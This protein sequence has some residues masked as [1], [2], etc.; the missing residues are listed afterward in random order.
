MGDGDALGL[1]REPSDAVRAVAQV[2]MLAPRTSGTAPASGRSPCDA[3]AS[4]RPIVAAEDATR[5]ANAA[6]AATPRIGVSA[7]ARSACARTALSLSGSMPSIMSFSP[8]KMRPNPRT[9][10]AQVL[11]EPPL[12]EEGH[13]EAEADQQRRVVV[14]AERQQL[15]GEGRPDVGAQDDAHRL[16]EGEEPGLDE[17]DH[18]D[19]RGGRR[20][21]QR[22]RR[23][24][25]QER[26]EPVRGQVRQHLPEAG[27]RGPL[28]PVAGVLHPVEEQRHA[29]EED[30]QEPRG[31]GAT[32]AGRTPGQV[33]GLVDREEAA[34]GSTTRVIDALSSRSAR[35][36]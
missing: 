30:D 31:H 2:P 16:V 35:A 12:A 13:R 5:A 9:R 3:S 26:R 27:A 6:E 10:V 32:G 8:R 36:R 34:A 17:P 1:R 22:G 24:A 33:A 29:A 21:D 28:E 25:G 11:E 4:T 19:R 14:D 18:H 15:D 7:K 23:G 20:L